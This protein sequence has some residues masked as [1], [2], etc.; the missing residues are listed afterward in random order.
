MPVRKTGYLIL[1]NLVEVAGIEPAYC[2]VHPLTSTIIVCLF[3]SRPELRQTGSQDASLL[4]VPLSY[5]HQ[6]EVSLLYMT[7]SCKRQTRLQ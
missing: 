4:G 6:R 2:T 1:V 7:L 3:V 5:R